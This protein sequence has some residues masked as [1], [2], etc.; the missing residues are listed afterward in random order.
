MMGWRLTNGIRRLTTLECRFFI[1]GLVLGRR[2]ES[3][4]WPWDF[5]GII[6]EASH[7]KGAK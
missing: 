5:V 6:G 2:S 4:T 7:S 1:S 3:L